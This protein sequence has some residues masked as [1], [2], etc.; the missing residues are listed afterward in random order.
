MKYV[1]VLFGVLFGVT[2]C[3]QTPQVTEKAASVTT[4]V[5]SASSVVFN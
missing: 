4:E 2:A 1:S 5:K 3:N